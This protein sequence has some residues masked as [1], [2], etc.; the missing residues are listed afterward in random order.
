MMNN[1]IEHGNNKLLMTWFL[2]YYIMSMQVKSQ[3]SSSLTIYFIF[4]PIFNCVIFMQCN[5]KTLCKNIC[6]VILRWYVLHFNYHTLNPISYV[7]ALY[8][9][10][11]RRTRELG[12]LFHSQRGN[13]VLKYNHMTTLV[14]V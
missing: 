3:H 5:R 10:M 12:F 9:I 13:I 1:F 11:H 7:V 4:M 8:S 6:G 14:E 2:Q